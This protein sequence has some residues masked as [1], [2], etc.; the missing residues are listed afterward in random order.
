MSFTLLLFRAYVLIRISRANDA[1]TLYNDR[2]LLRS[3][4]GYVNLALRYADRQP[5]PRYTRTCRARL[6][7][8]AMFF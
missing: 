3:L 4:L 6:G 7:L 1:F 8:V 5:A 2:R